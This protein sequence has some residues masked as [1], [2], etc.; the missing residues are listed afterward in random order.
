M[1]CIKKGTNATEILTTK[2]RNKKA[3]TMR[4][5][6]FKVNSI[7]YVTQKTLRS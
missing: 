6:L 4:L 3:I 2:R 7:D 5:S 1:K